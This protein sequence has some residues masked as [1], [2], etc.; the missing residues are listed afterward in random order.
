MK[1]IYGGK[2]M[3]ILKD[4]VSGYPSGDVTGQDFVDTLTPGVPG[5]VGAWTAVGLAVI[6]GLLV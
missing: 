1:I 4:L 5:W 2:I 3:D 6:F